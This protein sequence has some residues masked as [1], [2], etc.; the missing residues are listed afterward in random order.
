MFGRI[1]TGHIRADRG[2]NLVNAGGLHRNRRD[3]TGYQPLGHPLQVAG[4]TANSCTGFSSI[5]SG[6]AT[7]WLLELAE[8]LD[9]LVMLRAVA[10]ISHTSGNVIFQSHVSPPNPF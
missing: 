5:P 8:E 4:N 7:K 6:T 9:A 2:K 10:K 3:T 1:P